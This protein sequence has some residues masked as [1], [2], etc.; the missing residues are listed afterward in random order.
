[1][2]ARQLRNHLSA[3]PA[4]VRTVEAPLIQLIADH[5]LWQSLQEDEECFSYRVVA[6]RDCLRDTGVQA[7]NAAPLAYLES[8]TDPPGGKH[9]CTGGPPRARSPLAS[10]VASCLHPHCSGS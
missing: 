2:A 9:A 10:A 7:V 3:E 5:W 1:M 8:E 6:A 4:V